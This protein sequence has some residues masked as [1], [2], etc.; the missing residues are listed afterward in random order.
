MKQSIGANERFVIF[1]ACHGGRA[2][3]DTGL[4]LTNQSSKD[5]FDQDISQKE[6][7]EAVKAIS[8]KSKTVLLDSC[9]SEA[10]TRGDARHSKRKAH[11]YRRGVNTKGARKVTDQ[12]DPVKSLG[13]G[14]DVCYF[15]AA[16]TYQK[17]HEDEIDGKRQGYFTYSLN[18]RLKSG[19]ERWSEVQRDVSE[20]VAQ[21][22]EETQSPMI[23][24]NFADKPVFGGTDAPVASPAPQRSLWDDFLEEHPDASMLSLI[25]ASNASQVT[26]NKEK[27]PLSF[28]AGKP[29]YV[30]I[31][32][33]DDKGLLQMLWPEKGAEQAQ[34]KAGETKEIG[35]YKMDELGLQEFKALLFDD[36]SK[37]NE[38][39]AQFPPKREMKIK[40]AHKRAARKVGDYVSASLSFMVVPEEGKKG[41][42][43]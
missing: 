34:I 33:R 1:F 31:L 13:V 9:F 42:R 8:A 6:L 16:R 7:Y 22:S 41:V 23:S 32:A 35:P 12:D 26:L 40:D 27:H 11:F 37:V 36:V 19:A 5:N 30:V 4:L 21:R 24:G 25:S 3:D 15:V 18:Q 43:P 29:G 28:K 17:A 10:M 14:E 39:I 20:F 2:T 38:M